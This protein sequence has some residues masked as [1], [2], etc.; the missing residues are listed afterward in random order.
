M[1][2]PRRE[3]PNAVLTPR[4]R[5]CIPRSLHC[6]FL[7][8]PG[9]GVVPPIWVRRALLTVFWLGLI[10]LDV[11]VIRFVLL[12][13]LSRNEAE[14][15]LLVVVVV[16]VAS[17]VWLWRRSSSTQ[18]EHPS[19]RRKTWNRVG[20]VV[21]IGALAVAVVGTGGGIFLWLLPFCTG[22]LVVVFLKSL[23]P[24]TFLER[25]V[26]ESLET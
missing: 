4:R 13:A 1:A 8:Q 2:R 20:G 9:T 5:S 6:R 15:F 16:G 25:Q 14:V 11:V 22:F 17:F 18:P 23:A 19:P 21:T 10:A 24:V 7:V 12:P 26:R 3:T